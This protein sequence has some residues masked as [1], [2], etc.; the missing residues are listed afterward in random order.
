LR[1]EKRE[2]RRG[3]DKDWLGGASHSFVGEGRLPEGLRVVKG[4]SDG[5]PNFW[6]RGG[7]ASPELCRSGDRMRDRQSGRQRFFLD[8]SRLASFIRSA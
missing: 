1:E 3:H 6:N 4:A 8:E 7:V 5:Y 2:E